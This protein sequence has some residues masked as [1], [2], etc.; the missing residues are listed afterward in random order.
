MDVNHGYEVL[1]RDLASV[2]WVLQALVLCGPNPIGR[3]AACKLLN[4]TPNLTSK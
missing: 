1:G 2:I 3:Q 4:T